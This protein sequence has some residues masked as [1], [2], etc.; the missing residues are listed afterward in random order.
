MYRFRFRSSAAAAAVFAAAIAAYGQQTA[1]LTGTIRDTSQA[2]IEAAVV[3]ATNVNT[4][5]VFSGV[6]TADGIYTIPL[7]KPGDYKVSAEAQGFKQF[8]Q[9]GVRLETGA[10]VRIDFTLEV[11]AVAET[12]TVEASAPL[13]NTDTSSVGSVVRNSTIANMPLIDRRAAQLAK[14]N[15]F[16]VQNGNGSNF[17][18]AGGRGNN[19]MWTIDGGNAQNILLGVATLSYDPPVESLEEFNVEISNYKA[20]LGR[21]GGGYIQMTTKSGTNQF[22]GSL[23]E[24]LRNDKLDARNFF[25]ESKPVLRYNQYGASLGGPIRKDKTFFFANYE[26]LEIRRQQTIVASVPGVAETRGDFSGLSTTIRDPETGLPFPGNIIPES[27]LDPVGAAI[28]A[29]YPAPNVA[30]ARSRSNNFRANQAIRTTTHVAVARIDHNFSI[31]DRVYG[32]FLANETDTFNAPVYPTPGVDPY[33]SRND[34]SYYSWSATWQ[35]NFSPL[36]ILEAR[37][38]WDRRKANVRSGGADLGL[39]QQFGIKGTNDRFFPKINIP[40][41]TGFGTGN[42]E[43]LQ[44]PIRGDHY[45]VS[46][47]KIAGAHTIKFGAEYRRSTNDDRWSGTAGGEFSFNQTATGDPLASFLL[48]WAY[49]G[50]RAEA[51]LLRTRAT[52][53]GAYVQTDWKVT[54]RLT[55]NLGL[56]WDI[57]SPRRELVDNRQNSFDRYAINPVSNTPGVITWSGRNGLSE[58]AHNFDKNNFGPRVG[59]A[60]RATDKWVIRGGGGVLYVGQYDQATPIV[61]NIGFGLRSDVV[62]PDGGRTPAFL[63]RNGLPPATPPSNDLL[64]PG[65]GA[66]RPGENPT[67]AVEFFEPKGRAVPYLFTFNFNIQ[68]QL[69]GN[70]VFEIGYLSTLGHKLTAPGSRSI[71]QVPPDLIGPGNVQALRPFPQFSDVRVIAPTIGNSNYHGLNLKV[72]KR[73]SKG[74]QFSANYTW[75]KAIDDVESRDEIGGNAGDNAFANQYDRRADR[76]LSGNHIG[77]RFIGSAVWELPV[78][79]GRLLK[80]GNLLDH[81]I[82]GWSTSLIFEARSG[83]PFGVIENN[84]AA[85]YPTAATVRSSAIAPY[86]KNPNWR[87]NVLGETYFDTSVFVAPALYTFGN[88]GRTVAIG[89]GAIISDLAVLKNFTIREQQRLQFR[90]EILNFPN[91]ANFAVPNQNRGVANFGRISSLLPGNQAR[92]IQLGLHYKF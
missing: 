38:S 10:T 88:L 39:A 4:G 36:T 51:L 54:Q 85:I 16:V 90:V 41:L 56:R 92:I 79:K 67:L 14:L 70:A 55:L 9:T 31:N 45:T 77:H 18:M 29:L 49:S 72:E 75:S 15:G 52:A 61:A 64:V 63:L 43:R 22:H 74:L 17:A 26:G 19:A 60:Y 7:I 27:R 65:Y 62:S 5:E 71:N 30:G 24:F 82:G 21:S 1:T 32:R 59:F 57:D 34:N 28:A 91:R 84:A 37:Y 3:K 53:F 83:S 68:R 46:V 20:E 33:H 73:F 35:H 6:T 80:A 25:A 66:A 48:G 44:V 89:P 40:G 23:Y 86:R 47:T 11:G 2:V 42:H 13:L 69:P 76:G 87:S 81:V 8:Q 50:S 58:Y 12:V 78:G